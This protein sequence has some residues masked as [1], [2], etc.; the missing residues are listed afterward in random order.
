VIGLHGPAQSAG[1]HDHVAE[2]RVAGR[3]Q[4]EGD[5][6][7]ASRLSAAVLAGPFAR[8]RGHVSRCAD[9]WHGAAGSTASGKGEYEQR[10]QREGTSH[11]SPRGSWVVRGT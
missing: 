4:G 6:A 5:A 10:K 9:E 11:G 7:A 1:N 2:R 3:A 8:Q